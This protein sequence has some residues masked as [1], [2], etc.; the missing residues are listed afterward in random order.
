MMRLLKEER[1]TDYSDGCVPIFLE[2]YQ[3]AVVGCDSSPSHIVVKVGNTENSDHFVRRVLQ[4]LIGYRVRY[5]EL[6][7]YHG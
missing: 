5:G 2:L 1:G 3:V 4:L 6:G 7:C